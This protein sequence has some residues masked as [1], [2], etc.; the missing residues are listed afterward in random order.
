MGIGLLMPRIHDPI[1]MEIDSGFKTNII[2][3]VKP[4]LGGL[5]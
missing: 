1:S 2:L 4:L 3:G 5:Q